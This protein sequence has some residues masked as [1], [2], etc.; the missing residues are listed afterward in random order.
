VKG[1]EAK[2]RDV[3][4]TVEVLALTPAESRHGKALWVEAELVAVST[5]TL[6][7]KFSA[8]SLGRINTLVKPGRP[9][10]RATFTVPPHCARWPLNRS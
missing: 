6:F 7:V 2:P 9:K 1:G 8:P 5:N 3:G 4:K 10:V